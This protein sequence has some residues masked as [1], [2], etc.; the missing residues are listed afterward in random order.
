MSFIA[1]TKPNSKEI[2]VDRLKDGSPIDS[3][4]FR[5]MKGSEIKRFIRQQELLTH[6]DLRP[7][8]LVPKVERIEGLRDDGEYVL[9]TYYNFQ[10]EE[11][12][13][14][15]VLD[16]TLEEILKTIIDKEKIFTFEGR[17]IMTL[18]D[19]FWEA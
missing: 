19:L 13:S 18:D 4:I 11:L 2:R 8:I 12:D 9:E 14:Y 10:D 15:K 5:M 3:M 1:I 7:S 6:S 16:I 17:S